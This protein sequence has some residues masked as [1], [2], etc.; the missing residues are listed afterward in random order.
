MSGSSA[1]MDIVD[2]S[3][4]VN[5]SN[6]QTASQPSLSI[7]SGSSLSFRLWFSDTAVQPIASGSTIVISSSAGS[8]AGQINAVMPSTNR[9]G[10]RETSFTLTNDVDTP[11]DATITAAITSPSGIASTVVFQVTLN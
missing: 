7:A 3:N 5:F 8:L 9:A 4:N 2:T 1:L 6:Y 11:V 10:A